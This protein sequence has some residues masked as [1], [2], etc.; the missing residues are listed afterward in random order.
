[1]NQ[2]IFIYY[3]PNPIMAIALKTGGDALDERGLFGPGADCPG[4]GGDR[5]FD[6]KSMFFHRLREA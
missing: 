6:K 2:T 3:N 4:R 5:R 1:M